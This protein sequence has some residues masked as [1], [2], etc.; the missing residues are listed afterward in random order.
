[1][2]RSTFRKIAGLVVALFLAPCL[3][4][5]QITV[6]TLTGRVV[7]PSGSVIVGAHV[8]VISETQNTRT[9]AV[10]TPRAARH[11]NRRSIAPAWPP[12]VRPSAPSC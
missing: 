4:L 3:A 5:A 2:I 9:A 6:G 12:G 10:T 8:D 11:P 1:M 7:N